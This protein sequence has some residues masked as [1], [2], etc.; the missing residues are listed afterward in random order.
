M[1]GRVTTLVTQG[2]QALADSQVRTPA[3]SVS[4][5]MRNDAWHCG[6]PRFGEPLLHATLAYLITRARS[7]VA[8]P[9]TPQVE[10]AIDFYS[11]ALRESL[12]DQLV[13]DLCLRR[14]G[15]FAR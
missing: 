15:A 1:L 13:L 3:S 9:P 14:S 7:R 6:G 8:L 11:K 12:P 5:R 4:Q 2:D 10:A